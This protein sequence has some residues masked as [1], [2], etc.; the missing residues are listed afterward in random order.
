MIFQKLFCAI[1]CTR[2]KNWFTDLLVA[3][4]TN[5]KAFNKYDPFQTNAFKDLDKYI[6]ISKQSNFNI[7]RNTFPNYFAQ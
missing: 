5:N 1:S 2:L 7:C 6:L 3:V 4:K